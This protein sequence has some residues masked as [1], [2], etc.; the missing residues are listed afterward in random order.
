MNGRFALIC[1]T[2]LTEFTLPP[3]CKTTVEARK[4]ETRDKVESKAK[5]Q[6]TREEPTFSITGP[7]VLL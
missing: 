5:W 4:P 1:R 3:R 7:E 2:I 6:M